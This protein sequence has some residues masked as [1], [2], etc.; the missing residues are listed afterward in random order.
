MSELDVAHA[1]A[2]MR[3]LGL[4]P[5]DGSPVLVPGAVLLADLAD[6][7]GLTEA[8]AASAGADGGELVSRD[9]NHALG[10]A[11]DAVMSEGG[12][13][14]KFAGDGLLCIFLGGDAAVEAAS[15]ASHAIAQ[16]AVRGPDGKNHGFRSAIAHGSIKLARIGGHRERYELV[17]G[18]DA[19]EHVY[20]LVETA[21]A[22]MPGSIAR[23]SSSGLKVPLHD[24]ADADP[25]SYLPA[26]VRA[27]LPEGLT[28]WM[29]E[30]RTLTIA[31][32]GADLAA[33]QRSLQDV[34]LAIQTAADGQGGQLVR[35]SLEAQR[36][37]AEIAFGLVVGV[38]ATGPPEALQFAALVVR[39]IA[40]ARAGISTGRVFLGPIGSESRRQLTSLGT[41]VNFAAR[42]MQ[43]AASGEV[44]ADD[45]TWA[46]ASGSVQGSHAQ[47][48]LKGIGDRAFWRLEIAHLGVS[49]EKEEFFGRDKE[50]G[51]V[52]EAL[53]MGGRKACPIVIQG[54]AG[55]GKSRFA[56]WLSS[57]LRMR[58]S[59][60]WTAIA[61]PVGRDTPYSALASVIED[62][63]GLQ[64]GMDA[65][66]RLSI[67]ARQ[68]LGSSDRA[69]LLGDA[70]RLALPDTAST[71]ALIGG[72]RADNI[73]EALSMLFADRADRDATAL[74]VDDAH[75]L[76][77]SS[78]ALLQ[79]LASEVDTL[80]IVIV[81]RPMVGMEPTSLQTIRARNA[82]I[83]HL[84]PLL[85]QDITALLTSRMES[86]DVPATVAEWVIE[87]AK[88]NP[89]FAQELA[90]MLIALG[91]VEI[92]AGAIART[93]NASELSDLPLATTIE[94]TIEQ[95]IDSL[96]VDDAAALKVAS[97]IGPTF[98]IEE[99][100]NLASRSGSEI[101]ATVERLV[102]SD[103]TLP[104]G[105]ETF[106]FRHRYTQEAAY[107]MLTGDKRRLLHRR[108]GQAIES[109]LAQRAEECAGELAHHWFAAQEWP[110]ALH[111]LE[112]AGMQALRTGADQE[113]VTHFRRALSIGKDQP[114]GRLAA[115][116]RQLGRALLGLG[117][118]EGVAVEAR[119]AFELLI[120]PLPNSPTGWIG[121][122]AI[123]AF[124]RLSAPLSSR[125]AT[126]A[127]HLGT[128]QIPDEELIEGARAAGLLAESAYFVNA[129]EMMLGSALLAVNLA[130]RA[131]S[132]APVSVAFGMLGVVAGMARLHGI[133]LRYLRRACALSEDAGD[134][135]QQGVAWFYTGMYFGCIGDWDASLEAEQRA[136]SF[137]EEL[138][139]HAQSGFQL[140]II[141]TNALYTSEYAKT[142][143]WMKIVWEHAERSVNVQQQGWTHNVLS[144]ADLH[145]AHYGEALLR[146]ERARQIFL[147]ERDRIS[148][149]ISEGVQCVALCRLGRMA[150]AIVGA[151]RASEVIAGARPTTWG[152]LEGFAG[153]CE[154]YATALAH[155]LLTKAEAQRRA[156]AA[157][158]G[159]RLFAIVFPFGQARYHWICALFNIASG[160]IASARRRLRRSIVLAQRF[161]MT[162]EEMHG[163]ELLAGLVSA[164]E[165]SRL[166]DQT[167]ALKG[168]V[169]ET[170]VRATHAQHQP[171]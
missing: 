66:H 52:R 97:V 127:S 58:G 64:P 4:V 23:L 155:G 63:C 67:V 12:E 69:P 31:F 65:A 145:Q 118:V 2:P 100:S 46:A 28:D 92:R 165:Q 91:K 47:A 30:F 6:F 14:A 152:Q 144:V 18:G 29:R 113:A 37:V 13:V 8:L 124:D 157:M 61:T 15:R 48:T 108:M 21:V 3:L 7:T 121:L 88:G 68:L 153:P 105:P 80:R 22:G 119:K 39:D 76:D 94:S 74:I 126:L 103:M 19:V 162:Y 59:F 158:V 16:C 117:Q 17:A 125:V 38:A 70:L 83:V 89:F 132:A 134:P 112:F 36:L 102:A 146:S 54:E 25:S 62:L 128:R 78:W 82:L 123:S 1:F 142:R 86:C 33:G 49:I 168:L 96:R 116:H 55:I 101:A 98:S 51:V 156:R 40:G 171:A 163:I 43:H 148:L 27:R 111:W 10:P 115:W 5:V 109:R 9:L 79:R 130:E 11:V 161:R 110:K 149:I 77:S 140:T 26:Y 24:T 169:E 167:H 99:L 106:A 131:S 104:V 95:R 151:D 72:V 138:G 150:E 42:L 137:T 154:V 147:V 44:L 71:E 135:L 32:V 45:T 114:R 166:L 90:A 60:T 122:T 143:A 85:P 120:R 139:A 87:R 20:S 53:A 164:D 35:F 41:A 129:P 84:E 50:V 136:L 133:A 170:A 81:A 107:R 93:P 56:R 73:R 141:A 75:W 159:L 160:R 34:A 57:E